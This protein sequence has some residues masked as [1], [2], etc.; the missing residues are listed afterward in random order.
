MH[1]ATFTLSPTHLSGDLVR[2]EP[3]A[4]A[5]RDE[6]RAALDC[7]PEA[8]QLFMMSGQGAHFESWWT[9]LTDGVAAGQWIAYAI[10]E[11]ASGRIVG[12]SSF[13]NIKPERQCV[14]IGA[15]F[16]HPSVRATRVNA[17]SKL[18][19]LEQAFGNGVRRVELLTDVRNLRSQAA[20]SK[21]GAVREGVLRRDRIIWTGHIRDSV[22]YAITDLDW[23]GVKA[24]LTQRLAS[25]SGHS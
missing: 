5:L 25:T 11:R 1:D 15:T 13:L 24:T 4:D 3:Y 18:L 8:W 7:D 16:L 20:I 10:R 12:T 21:L 19:M 17:E 14:E 6:V 9:R 23:P 22:L 2:L